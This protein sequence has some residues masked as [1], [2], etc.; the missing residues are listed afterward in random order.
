VTGDRPRRGQRWLELGTLALIVATAIAIFRPFLIP[1]AWAA[2]LVY[3]S[4]PVF[5][6]VEAGLRGRTAWAAG[7]MTALVV[8]VV[9]APAVLV[10]LALAGEAQ[11]VYLDLKAWTVKQP[12]ALPAW[13]GQIPWVGPRIMGRL[14]SL[15][16]DPANAQQWLLAQ[17]GPWSRIIVT[18]VGDLGRNLAG[19]G[20]ALFALFFLYR[21]GRTLL[22][23][24]ERAA[25]RLAGDRVH[26]MLL[27]LGQ[28]VRAVTYGML[29]TA[30]AQGALATLGY[31]VAGLGAPV[32]LGA[33]TTIL[34][35]IPFGAPIVY[36]PVSAW[37][38]VQGRPVAGLLLLAWG[39]L[40]VSTVDNLIRSWFI[41]GT[42][43]VPFLLVFLGVLG[44][45]ATF[46][47]IGLFVGP[48]TI[49]LLLVLWREWTEPEPR[50]VDAP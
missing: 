24:V 23:Q 42:T 14:E 27:P 31:W 17:A 28:T 18:T 3:A 41:S 35:L 50:E 32:L 13:V 44:G 36:V 6:R 22:S 30:L 1:L 15:V 9:V 11:Q 16:A 20:L 40:V 47:A 38:L 4:W 12:L 29:L 10:S 25:R 26:A 49:T 21:H 39:I 33:T 5:L 34:A 45:L 7:A 19:A 37:L 2:I 43:Q 8:L 46:G 48:V